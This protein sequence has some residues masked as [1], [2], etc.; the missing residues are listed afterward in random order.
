MVRAL[1]VAVIVI[2]CACL[3]RMADGQSPPSVNELPPGTWYTRRIA[4]SGR[5]TSHNNVRHH[6]RLRRA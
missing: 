6:G 1:I 4:S 2:A 5:G 3:T